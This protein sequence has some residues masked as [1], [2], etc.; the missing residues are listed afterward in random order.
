MRHIEGRLWKF[1][2]GDNRLFYFLQLERKF[3]IL[4]GYRKKNMKAP[5][6]EIATAL[7]RIQELLEE[8]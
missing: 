5:D 7:R 3:V 4:F 2:P 1:R 6:K 8:R